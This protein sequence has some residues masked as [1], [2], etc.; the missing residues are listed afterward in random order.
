MINY[1]KYDKLKTGLI[2]GFML[3]LIIGAGILIFS[4]GNLSIS[5]YLQ[6]I[7]DA[8]ILTHTTSLCVF[9][10]IVIFLIFNRLDMLK[11]TKGVLAV[12]IFWAI[13]VFGIKF[14]S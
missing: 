12:T 3:P 4:R 11:A 14:L 13:I 6:K 5:G 9:P 2:S 7:I 1:M 10:N 8:D